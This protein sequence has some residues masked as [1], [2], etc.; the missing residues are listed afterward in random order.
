MNRITYI[1]AFAAALW[2]TVIKADP[3]GTGSHGYDHMMWGGGF[4]LFGGLMMLAFWSAIIA[5]IYLAVRWFSDS[6]PTSRASDALD[7]LKQRFAKGEID[8]DEYRK[9]KLALED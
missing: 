5:L 2:A 6:K 9:R 4:G 1:L 8:E 7:I 3:S